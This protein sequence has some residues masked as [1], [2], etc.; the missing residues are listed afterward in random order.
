MCLWDK[1]WLSTTRK[2]KRSGLG[3]A[4]MDTYKRAKQMLSEH[5]R[6]GAEELL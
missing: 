3:V 6:L 4:S 2:D 5:R 1:G